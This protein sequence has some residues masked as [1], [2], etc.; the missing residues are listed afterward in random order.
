[1]AGPV[2]ARPLRRELIYDVG[3]AYGFGELAWTPRPRVRLEP[4]LL[5]KHE[6][7]PAVAGA[8]EAEPVADFL[9][10]SRFP[11]F[12]VEEAAGGAW[13][14]VGDARFLGRGGGWLTERVWVPANPAPR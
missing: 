7:H 4:D 3:D 14:Q 6:D 8:R 1:M 9:V 13:V 11:F 2:P 10:W 12:R 5:P